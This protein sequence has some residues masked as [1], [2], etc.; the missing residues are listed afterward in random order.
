MLADAVK[1]ASP[2]LPPYDV[3]SMAER[4]DGQTT[5]DQLA[6]RLMLGFALAALLLAV[7]GVYG[8]ISYG[9]SMRTREIGIRSAL[10]ATRS[11]AIWMVLRGAL[12]PLLSGIILG[13]AGI[14]VL[15]RFVRSLLY[16]A[17]PGDPLIL[18]GAALLLLAIGVAASIVPALRASRVAPVTA[19]RAD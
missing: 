4:L 10:G 5:R 12:W 18:G 2:G 13:L 15:Q 16:G 3:T 17:D 7:V 8:V 11:Q 14:G 1:R 6:V 9:V 19:L